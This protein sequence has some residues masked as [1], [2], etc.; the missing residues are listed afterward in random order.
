MPK[1]TAAIITYNEERKI[2]RCLRS[3]VWV[4]EIVI[5]DSFS[6]DRTVDICKRYTQ[7]IFQHVWPNNYSEQKTR[8]HEHASHDWILFI[9]ADEVVTMALRDEIIDSFKTVPVAQAFAI[10]RR[11]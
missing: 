2:E 6:T 5:I 4:D 7:K 1:I 11:E 10:P 3:L 9:D 8:A